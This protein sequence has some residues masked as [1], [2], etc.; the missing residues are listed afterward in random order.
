MVRTDRALERLGGVASTAV[1]L[2]HTSRAQLRTALRR[3]E[4]VRS[5]RGRYELP[6]GDEAL[7]AANRLT[8]VLVEDSAA[9]FHGWETKHQPVSPCVAVPR[10]RNVLPSRRRGLRLRF[11]DL[12]PEEVSGRA[13]VPAVTVLHCAARLP[14]DEALAVADSALRHREVSRAELL[15]LAEAA[16]ARYRTRCR[17]V[18]LQADGR[19][20]NPFESV[21]RAIALGVEGLHV[22]PQVWVG[23][24]G[25]PDLYD[26]SLGLVLEADSFEFHGRRAALRGDCERYNGFV[27]EG[28]QVLRFA[29]EHVMHDPGYVHEVLTAA[30]GGPL[31][32]ALGRRP[33]RRSA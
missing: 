21:L 27:L 28:C 10:H 20:A 7:S 23:E 24:V 30:V 31:G 22:E 18:A 6:G 11:I 8:G 5:S 12:G 9:R 15:A 29:Y 32:R 1:L 26:R 4:V 25:R 13:T 14:F 16:P 3:G 33:L 19:A 2:Q 17:R